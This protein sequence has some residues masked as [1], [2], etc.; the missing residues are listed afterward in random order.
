[1]SDD[2]LSFLRGTGVAEQHYRFVEALLADPELSVPRAEAAVGMKA[3]AGKRALLRADVR[4]LLASLISDRRSRQEEIRDQT[5][6]ML[7]QIATWDPA[8]LVD[9]ASPFELKPL[10]QLPP[11]VRAAIVG[12]KMS[13]DGRIEYKLTDRTKVLTALLKHFGDLGGPGGALPDGVLDVPGESS[14]AQ[15]IF[16]AVEKVPGK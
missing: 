15:I 7:A 9:E 10:T 5:I 11:A 6:Q 1:M 4:R 8:D 13:P 12:V 3:G 16:H 2:T 14:G